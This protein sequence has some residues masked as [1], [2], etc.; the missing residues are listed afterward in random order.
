VALA[1]T[2][3]LSTPQQAI[4]SLFSLY[5]LLDTEKVYKSGIQT[6]LQSRMALL[7][8]A[9]GTPAPKGPTQTAY[10]NMVNL[11]DLAARLHGPEFAAYLVEEFTPFDLLMHL[12]RVYQTVLLPGVGFAGP[13]WTARV[14]L[15]NLP[16]ENYTVI[17]Q[18]LVAL[19]QDFHAYWE[20]TKAQ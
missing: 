8:A 2:G 19:M 18:N 1:H 9:L 6:L 7:Y 14:S 10:Y 3:G 17:G 20:Q 5:E 13:D 12:A 15:A 11:R 4:M 16:D